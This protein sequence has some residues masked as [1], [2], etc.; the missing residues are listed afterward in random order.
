MTKPKRPKYE[1]VQYKPPTPQVFGN[2][3][4]DDLPTAA[5]VA[6]FSLDRPRNR[7]KLQDRLAVYEDD[8][9]Q[10]QRILCFGGFIFFP[11]WFIGAIMWVRTPSSKMLNREAGFKNVLMS[12][13]CVV[14]MLCAGLYHAYVTRQVAEEGGTVPTGAPGGDSFLSTSLSPP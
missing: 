9:P 7:P 13:I 1:T 6:N 4:P 11:F 5:P 10:C 14:A 8:N 12:T 2:A 3:T